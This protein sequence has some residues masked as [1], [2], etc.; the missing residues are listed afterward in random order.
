MRGVYSKA[1]FEGGE[2]ERGFAE[3]AR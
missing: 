3:Q 1:L 2:Q